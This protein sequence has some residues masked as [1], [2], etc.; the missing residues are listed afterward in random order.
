MST[1]REKNVP[2]LY[3][4]LKLTTVPI[5]RY[6]NK[7]YAKQPCFFKDQYQ[8]QLHL[9]LVHRSALFSSCFLTQ[10]LRGFLYTPIDNAQ[11]TQFILLDYN[12]ILFR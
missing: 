9:G 10:F 6:R 12:R 7:L 2:T 11:S 4:Y 3:V 1:S 8:Y 5:L